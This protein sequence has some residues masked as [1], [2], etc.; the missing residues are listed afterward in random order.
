MCR[1]YVSLLHCLHLVLMDPKGSISEHVSK[2]LYFTAIIL[3]HKYLIVFLS[4]LLHECKMY[5]QVSG[6]VASLR[7]F[8][9][10]G[11]TG[12]PQ[13][14]CAA[15]GSKENEPGSLSLKLTSEEPKKTN[16]TPYRPPHLRKKEG[17]NMRQAKAQDAQSSSDHDSSMVDITSSDSDYSD[18]DGSLN[19]I[20]S[21]RC[22]KVRVSAIVCVQVNLEHISFLFVTH[23]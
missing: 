10:Y 16:N 20:N 8:F 7:M 1:F 23:F 22:S 5:L 15:V 14:M 9:V 21:S 13:L 11:L 17:F 3:I 4:L 18:N 6:F 19:D 2:S 12:G